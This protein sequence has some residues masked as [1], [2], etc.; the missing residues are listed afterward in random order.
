MHFGSSSIV[1]VAEL[2]V[3]VPSIILAFVVCA[4]HGFSRSSG[5][6]YTFTL[7]L[8]RIA[9]AVCQ[10]ITRKDHS[11]GLLK[12]VLVLSHIGL[13]PLLLSTLGMLSRIADWINAR[14]PSPSLSIKYFRLA[15]LFVVLGAVFGIIGIESSSS[16][17]SDGGGGDD[18]NAVNNSP[19]TW[20]KVAVICYV[21]TYAM[22]LFL[23]A[24]SLS[25]RRQLPGKERLLVPAVWVA[26]PLVFV[27]LLYQVLV[28]FVHRGDF[29]RINAPIVVLVLM[30]VVEEFLV[31]FIFLFVG[32]RLDKLEESEQ[33]PILSRPWKN[34]DRKQRR[35]GRRRR[36]QD[37]YQEPLSS[38]QAPVP[39]EYM[40]DR[41]GIP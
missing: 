10:L 19:T 3:Y 41:H 31:V 16:S 27:R 37:K 17:S 1:A 11:I 34:R 29:R 13:T 5:W 9:G 15:Q 8:I 4:R 36:R 20:S 24:R 25:F 12:T 22:L 28:V 26:L 35:G 32:L 38:Y 39:M 14:S 2:V 21:A 6:Y 18:H 33:G 40:G 7:C 23:M 30:S